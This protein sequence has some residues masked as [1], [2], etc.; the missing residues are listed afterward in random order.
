MAATNAASGWARHPELTAAERPG[1]RKVRIPGNQLT[2]KRFQ[3]IPVHLANPES[4]AFMRVL[5]LLQGRRQVVG[6]DT[7][8]QSITAPAGIRGPCIFARRNCAAYLAIGYRRCGSSRRPVRA[9]SRLVLGRRGSSRGRERR[10]AWPN[11]RACAGSLSSDPVRAHRHLPCL[12]SRDRRAQPHRLSRTG[13]ARN[14]PTEGSAHASQSQ[15]MPP[16]NSANPTILVRQPGRRLTGPEALGLGVVCAIRCP[17]MPSSGRTADLHHRRISQGP[18][19]GHPPRPGLSSQRVRSGRPPGSGRSPPGPPRCGGL[20]RG[21]S[22]RCG[23]CARGDS[24]RWGGCMRGGSPRC[25][26]CA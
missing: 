2:T 7:L 18:R 20:A 23:G 3:G 25:G 17:G 5:N 4:P 6:R 14:A 15:L 19:R 24:P 13:T 11:P 9:G 12:R 26:G 10:R 16:K 21:G 8:C 22:T 1:L